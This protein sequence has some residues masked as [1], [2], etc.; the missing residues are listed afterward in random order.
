M[1]EANEKPNIDPEN[2]I[3]R[4]IN[5]C[6]VRLFFLLERNEKAERLILDNIMLAFD[7]K[8]QGVTRVRT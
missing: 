5:G 6:K 3:E 7:R 4:E 8:M 1:I 2:I